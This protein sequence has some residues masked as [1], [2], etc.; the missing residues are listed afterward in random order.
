VTQDERDLLVREAVRPEQSCH[1]VPQVVQA[2]KLTVLV[3]KFEPLGNARSL[4]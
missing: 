2:E 3:P 1:A 4:S